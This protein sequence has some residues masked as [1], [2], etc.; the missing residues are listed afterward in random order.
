MHKVEP[1]DR[2]REYVNKNAG[3]FL[4]DNG[5]KI[6]YTATHTPEQSGVA[7]RKN[8]SVLV[9]ARCIVCD[10]G[11]GQKYWAEAVHTANFLQNRLPTRSV[12]NKTPFEAWTGRKPDVQHLHI[13][14]IEAYLN[15]P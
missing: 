13:F 6:E 15:V 12:S 9:M 5:I 8:R 4:Q 1:S 3:R 7:E 2:G 11:M 10:S 14:G